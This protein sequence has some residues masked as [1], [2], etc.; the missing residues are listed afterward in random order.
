[1][2]DSIIAPDAGWAAYRFLRTNAL[3]FAARNDGY[4]I[5]PKS[6][7]ID[8]PKGW[9]VTCSKNYYRQCVAL[10]RLAIAPSAK[11]SQNGTDVT[12][13]A[14]G[15]DTSRVNENCLCPQCLKAEL[16]KRF[17]LRVDQVEVFFG[18][19]DNVWL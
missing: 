10:W 18:E 5:S 19:D 11:R 2:I 15:A 1:M 3:W 8:I 14:H 9:C 7:N 13:N 16:R 6:G 4:S 12:L 17:A